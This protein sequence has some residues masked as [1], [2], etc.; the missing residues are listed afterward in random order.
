[1]LI[2]LGLLL[3]Q[4][5][6]LHNKV[7]ASRIQEGGAVYKETAR[8]DNDTYRV[9]TYNLCWGC[10]EAD[11]ND[12]TGMRRDLQ[13]ECVKTIER[14]GV[15][16]EN[17]IGLP[18]TRCAQNMGREIAKYHQQIGGYDFMAFQEASNFGDLILASRGVKMT[19]VQYGEDL[20]HEHTKGANKGKLK[21]A[22][23]VSL[24]NAE[25]LGIHDVQVTRKEA[26]G[27][28][29]RPFLA[30]IFDAKKLM[31]VNVHQHHAW[32]G[33]SSWN[34]L[35]Q[36]MQPDLEVAFAEKPE[37]RKYRIIM[38]GDFNDLAGAL[39]GCMET[40]W[41]GSGGA[42]FQIKAPLAATCCSARLDTK[43]LRGYGDYIFDSHSIPTNRLPN[44]FDSTLPQSDHRPVEAVLEATGVTSR[45][46][47]TKPRR[48]WLTASMHSFKSFRSVRRR[49]RSSLRRPT[50]NRTQRSSMRN[51][52]IGFF[53]EGR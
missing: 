19:M 6:L 9:F 53:R 18:V 40:P 1:M 37:R 16:E 14:M 27:V 43:V 24:Y 42:L 17:G 32:E 50:N 33:F 30:L 23:V 36:A 51:S 12:R 49:G 2:L 26:E 39:P 41:E 28:I 48:C 25:R 22:W 15:K 31:F 29:G 46:T 10:M 13:R 34:N 5:V 45:L 44:D 20:E 7:Q 38:A 21:K 52:V 8:D 4:G 3:S 35:L 11:T 47:E